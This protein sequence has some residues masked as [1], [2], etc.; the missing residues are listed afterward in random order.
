APGHAPEEEAAVTLEVGEVHTLKEAPR[1]DDAEPHLSAARSRAGET[2]GG[3]RRPVVRYDGWAGVLEEQGDRAIGRETRVGGERLRGWVRRS[4]EV[5]DLQGAAGHEPEH[6]GKVASLRPPDVGQR[7]ILALL[8]VARIV[9][10]RP[11]RAGDEE[12]EL[13]AVELLPADP[14]RH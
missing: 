11:V 3:A 8:L 7:V 6:L 9:P 10:A 5:S 4:H 13:L 12:V 2:Q 1:A 14:D